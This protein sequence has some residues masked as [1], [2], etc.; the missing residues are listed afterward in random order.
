MNAVSLLESTDS[1]HIKAISNKIIQ[2][3]LRVVSQLVLQRCSMGHCC[4]LN[5]LR[6]DRAE[7]SNIFWGL[8][9]CLSWAVFSMFLRRG[10]RTVEHSLGTVA[11][12]VMGSL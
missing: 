4:I 6:S 10:G 9:P 3:I 1:K 2:K 11:L 8:W 12:F 5:S 7:L